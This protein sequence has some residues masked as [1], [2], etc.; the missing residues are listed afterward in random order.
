[1]LNQC[2]YIKQMCPIY[3]L[4]LRKTKSLF[5]DKERNCY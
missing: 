5:V 3:K 1:M 2:I 4:E